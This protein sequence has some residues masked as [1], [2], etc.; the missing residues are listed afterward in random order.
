MDMIVRLGAPFAGVGCL[1][2]V[3]GYVWLIMLLLRDIEAGFVFVILLF[4]LF[5]PLLTP[6]VWYFSI[7]RWDITKRPLMIHAIGLL[8]MVVGIS[9]TLTATPIN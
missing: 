2:A 4:S 6:F 8:I 1:F 5:I 9:L 7:K 3:V